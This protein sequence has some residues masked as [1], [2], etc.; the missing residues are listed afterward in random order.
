[1]PNNDIVYRIERGAG[2]KFV[3]S[4][5]TGIISVAPGA[6]LDPD[7]TDPKT[8]NYILTVV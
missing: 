7:L 8:N 6:S 1:M 5:D 2:D 4:P 3:I